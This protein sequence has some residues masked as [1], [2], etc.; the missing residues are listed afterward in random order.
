MDKNENAKSVMTRRDVLAVGAVALAA[1]AL[2]VPSASVQE[3][4]PGTKTVPEWVTSKELEEWTT[5]LI[6]FSQ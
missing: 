3:K 1:A 5:Q 6:P 2:P 4:A